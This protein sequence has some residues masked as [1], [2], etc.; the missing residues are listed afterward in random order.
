MNTTGTVVIMGSV[1]AMGAGAFAGIARHEGRS[2]ATGKEAVYAM[3][4]SQV[5]VPAD[6]IAA[7]DKAQFLSSARYQFVPNMTS[8]EIPRQCKAALIARED[9]RFQLHHGIDWPGLIRAVSASIVQHQK[10][11]AS[12]IT[13]QL[14]KNAF[15]NA[16]RSGFNGVRRKLREA[17]LAVRLER[18]MS[19]ADIVQRYFSVVNFGTVNHVTV[20]GLEQAAAFYFAKHAADLNVYECATLVG[21]LKSPQTLNPK[22]HPAAAHKRARR[23]L[24]DMVV[25]KQLTQNEMD[26]A[27]RSR[28]KRGSVK[29]S[30]A[31]GRYALSAIA[32]EAFG[33]NVSGREGEIRLVVTVNPQ[34][35]QLAERQICEMTKMRASPDFQGALVAMDSSSGEIRALVG[36]CNFAK[37]PFNRATEAK[38]QPGS[39][40][41]PFVYAR[42][43][44]AGLS[45]STIRVDAPM[46]L[47]GYRP[48]NSDRQ[49]RGP[50]T[51][52]A[53][54]AKSINTIAVKLEAEIGIDR[55][56]ELA[57]RFGIASEIGRNWSTA[58]G[59]SEVTLLELTRAYA[60]FANSGRRVDAHLIAMSV[61]SGKVIFQ[62]PPAAGPVVLNP[63]VQTGM[64]E[65][66]RAVVRAG[67]GTTAGPEAVGG[68]TGT[69]QGGRDAWFVGWRAMDAALIGV[70]AGNDGNEP[71][72]GLSG[73]GLPAETWK[74]FAESAARDERTP[75]APPISPKK[76]AGLEPSPFESAPGCRR[77]PNL[78]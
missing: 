44:E 71:V 42:A 28:S 64:R 8:R 24:A 26:T 27:L 25:N 76:V 60:P 56:I 57:H 2:L 23:V 62:R 55:V 18:E 41:K 72:A 48:E 9:R 68:K 37:H 39:A 19:K 43:L 21:S 74:K 53:G 77:Y 59:T 5:R 16:A 52:T 14:I 17:I 10:E 35:Q 45:P 11:G 73:H 54:L 51:L 12:T 22:M 30:Q 61:F 13:E 65:M 29:F 15:L 58:L 20:V 31:D 7:R 6:V 47:D 70:W 1:L 36:G 78:C 34:Y 50:V 46:N 75:L 63:R 38:R 3:S 4:H 49:Y 32:D 66:L 33:L 69:S 40:F 67:T